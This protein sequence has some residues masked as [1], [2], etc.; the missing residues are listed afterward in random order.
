MKIPCPNWDYCDGEIETRVTW[1]GDRIVEVLC[2]A[3]SC[4]CDLP[5]EQY[6]AFQAEALDYEESLMWGAE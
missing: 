1:L 3:Q 5:A 2:V 4:D 6:R